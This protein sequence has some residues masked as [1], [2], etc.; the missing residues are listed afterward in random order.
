MVESYDD[1][2]PLEKVSRDLLSAREHLETA[3]TA[4]TGLLEEVQTVEE[5][6]E[7]FEEFPQDLRAGTRDGF[8]AVIS[9][10]E[11]LRACLASGQEALAD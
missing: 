9:A 2:D 11:N 10:Q 7:L 8:V 3:L 4:P 6:V 5:A 1:C